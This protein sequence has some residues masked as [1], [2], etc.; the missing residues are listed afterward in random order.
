MVQGSH[1]HSPV[2]QFEIKELLHINLFGIDLSFTNS[3]LWML[4]VVASS[5]L[6]FT[7]AIRKRLLIPS[8]L[9][10]IVESFY[11][12]IDNII[13][14]NIGHKGHRYFKFIFSLFLFILLCN[15]C[16][17]LPYSFTPT[18]H[19]IVTFAIAI[20][21]FF[22]TVIITIINHGIWFFKVFVPQGTPIIMAPLIFVL[23]FF[24]YLAR[25]ISLSVR[26]AANMFAGH[27]MLKVIAAFVISMGIFG[28]LPMSFLI[29]MTGFEIFV[30]ILQ[31]YIFTLLTCVY[32]G[33]ALNH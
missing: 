33:D 8:R 17:M 10:L 18:S 11:L 20:V 16:G 19:I 14:D 12:M 6:F 26:L 27:I 31:A 22:I 32:I 13:K 28:L 15:L 23:E 25:P 7:I 5:I 4:I 3:S 29:I 24:S 30:A 2:S 21:V 9:Q 1:H